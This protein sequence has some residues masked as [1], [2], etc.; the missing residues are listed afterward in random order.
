MIKEDSNL[1][2][3]LGKNTKAF[4]KEKVCA[5][6]VEEE[7]KKLLAGDALVYPFI[8]TGSTLNARLSSNFYAVGSIQI[9]T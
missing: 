1:L 5:P 9:E 2:P 3:T 4:N 6:G 8:H 7:E